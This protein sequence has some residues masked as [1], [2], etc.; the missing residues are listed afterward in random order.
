M[1][2][3][4]STNAGRKPLAAAKRDVAL[5]TNTDWY[6][7]F[8]N[9][10]ITLF[11]KVSRTGM[12]PS[13]TGVGAL[14][15][16]ALFDRRDELLR[17]RFGHRRINHF[18]KATLIAQHSP[19]AKSHAGNRPRPALQSEG[20]DEDR[21]PEAPPASRPAS[22]ARSPEHASVMTVSW[23]LNLKPS[24]SVRF[25]A[26]RTAGCLAQP[27]ATPRLLETRHTLGKPEAPACRL[28][29]VRRFPR[30]LQI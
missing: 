6:A 3:V 11:E 7:P 16:R 23:S 8:L 26:R 22:L 19:L 28:S 24:Y 10:S 1:N 20:G 30:P 17:A 25:C 15:V 27:H 4:A 21:I 29:S 13:V 9:L 12:S 18:G 5:P 2:D 14:L